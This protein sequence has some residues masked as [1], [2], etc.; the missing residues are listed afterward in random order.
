MGYVQLLRRTRIDQRTSSSERPSLAAVSIASTKHESHGTH[1][2][3]R[4]P[5]DGDTPGSLNRFL[6]PKDQHGAVIAACPKINSPELFYKLGVSSEK[7]YAFLA[8]S[9]EPFL[10]NL[11]LR[12]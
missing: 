4:L 7:C 8:A 12:Y 3:G 2:L 1:P 9:D 5:V 11:Y 6:E 10:L